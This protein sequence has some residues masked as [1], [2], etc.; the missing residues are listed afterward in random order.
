MFC[1]MYSCLY[2]MLGSQQKQVLDWMDELAHDNIINLLSKTSVTL[3]MIMGQVEDYFC[4]G[5]VL[6]DHYRH[7]VVHH[8]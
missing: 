4:A 3:L 8:H 7:D 1:Y 6:V 5:L 2:K